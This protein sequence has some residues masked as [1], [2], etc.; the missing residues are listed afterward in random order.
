MKIPRIFIAATKQDEGK[1]T[2]AL[3]LL[4]HFKKHFSNV[5]FMK[6]VGQK[7]VELESGTKVDKDVWLVRESFNF[8]DE[9]ELMS[10][11]TIP[12]GFT[13]EYID[14]RKPELLSQKIVAAF[15]NLSKNKNFMLLE[16]TGHAGV[17]SV[18]D[19]SNARVAELLKSPVIIVSSG[20][21]G[22]P[23]DEIML[24]V[25]LF[26]ERGVKIAGVILNKVIPNKLQQIK[27]YAGKA[28]A[29]HGLELLGV[30]PYEPLLSEPTLTE[31]CRK[32]KGEV[33]CGKDKL[34]TLYSNA[35]FAADFSSIIPEKI[36]NKTLVVT[37]GSQTELLIA[38]VN[39]EKSTGNLHNKI[40]G[41][42]LVD[43]IKPK[44]HIT[45]F[46]K[47][48]GIPVVITEMS[49]FD[50][51]AKVSSMVAKTQPGN[52]EKIEKIEKLFDEYVNLEKIIEKASS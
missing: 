22:K 44:Q 23:I 7:F 14:N 29:W 28:L 37:T 35:V 40:S 30:I 1:T 9:A 41:I 16:G 32:V 27:D 19:L 15:K 4:L 45:K 24:N 43:G 52:P 17:G 5:G 33:L 12:S 13:K 36:K 48:A 3:G 2:A 39:E 47:S 18:I 11:V 50:A 20:G 42:L 34:S 26:K 6:P 10:P 49:A 31:V 21:I 46:L 38:C 51:T 8:N 25:S